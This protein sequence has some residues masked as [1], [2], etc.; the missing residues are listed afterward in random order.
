[1]AYASTG[2]WGFAHFEDS[3]P[4]GEAVIKTCFACHEATP[5][6]DLVFTRRMFML[7]CRRPG[8]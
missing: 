6:R 8:R 7:V 3:Q 2:G 4:A 5:E 1:M